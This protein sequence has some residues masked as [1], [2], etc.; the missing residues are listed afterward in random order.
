MFVDDPG[1]YH[2]WSFLA[3][4][5]RKWHQEKQIEEEEARIT[6]ARLCRRR[7]PP[8]QPRDDHRPA[9]AGEAEEDLQPPSAPRDI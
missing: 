1:G 2:A 6:E 5:R 8:Q 7:Q 4:Q 3:R 9:A